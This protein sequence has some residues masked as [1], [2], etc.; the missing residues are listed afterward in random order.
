MMSPLTGDA[1]KKFVS[2]LREFVNLCLAGKVPSSIQ[3]VFCGASLCALTKKDGGI[4]PIAVGCTLRRLVAKSVV[5][6]VQEKMAAKMAPVQL[7][8]GVKRETEASAHAVRRLLQNIRPGQAVLK[9]D[10]KNAFNA[11]SGDEVIRTIHDMLP[12][13]FQFV[14]TCYSSSSHICFG[15][16]LISSEEGVQQGIRSGRYYFTQHCLDWP[17]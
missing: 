3:P 5:K 17:N 16:F 8:F 12:E 4:R 1:E 6:V 7:G 2:H 9:L 14:S 11:I 15:N 13:L 10:F